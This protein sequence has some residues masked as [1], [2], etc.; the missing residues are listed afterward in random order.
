[1]K[2]TIILRVVFLTL[3]IATLIIIFGFSAQDGDASGNISR[4][5]AEAVINIFNKN[6]DNIANAIKQAEGI[7]RKLAHF[8][9]YASVGIWTM[10]LMSTFKTKESLMITISTIAGFI[11]ACTDE[12]H[13]YFV[14]GRMASFM[15]VI[16]DTL[17]AT[18]GVI[19]VMLI[20]K[21][22]KILQKHYNNI[23][24]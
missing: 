4:K 9:I 12:F 15:D 13:Q 17:G 20:I 10:S 3:L 16:I 23:K 19:L 8:S 7:I 14:N 21:I 5:I 6:S 22:Y 18:F 1:M 11:Y 2:K 24:I